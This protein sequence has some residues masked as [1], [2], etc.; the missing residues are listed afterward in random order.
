MAATLLWMIS[1][2][3]DE[4]PFQDGI[5]AQAVNAVTAD[6]ALYFS[7]ASNSGN[8]DSGTSGTW[9]GD[10]SDGGQTPSPLETGRIHDFASGR[11]AL[12]CLGL[13][14]G[15]SDLHADLFWADPLGASTNDYDLYVLNSSGNTV[16]ASSRNTQNGSQDPYESVGTIAKGELI[17][18][19]KYS[20]TGRFLHLSTGDGL[21]DISTQG[22][23]RGHN[24]A[25]NAFG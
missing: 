4:S 21:L 24:C 2:T 23:T 22:S 8:K 15:G 6:G 5:V 19:V 16:I 14:Q 25:T 10:F 9:E 11:N 3:W 17:V 20:G 18:I 13:G 12:T 7:S 1:C